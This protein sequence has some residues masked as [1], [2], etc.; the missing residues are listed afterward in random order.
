MKIF[1]I[2]TLVLTGTCVVL[3]IAAQQVD[4]NQIVRT[5]SLSDLQGVLPTLN[6]QP[7]ATNGWTWLMEAAEYNPNADVITALIQAGSPVNAATSQN[8]TSALALAAYSNPSA[9]VVSALLRAGADVNARNRYGATP[10][11]LAAWKNPNPQVVSVLLQGG[12]DADLRGYN[13][14]TALNAA[15]QNPA[16]Q[17]TAAYQQLTEA[18]S[19]FCFWTT[20][21]YNIDIYL[22]GS[23]VGKLTS[24]FTSGQPSWGQSGTLLVN[25][26]PGSYTVVGKLENGTEVGGPATSS[27]MHH[28]LFLFPDDLVAQAVSQ[29]QASNASAALGSLS[30][31]AHST[32]SLTGN[33]AFNQLGNI[34]SSAQKLTN[35]LSGNQ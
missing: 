27:L 17:N 22:N 32:A 25:V 34:F 14:G 33:N 9:D 21:N 4:A 3:P 2:V 7:N 31:I 35:A 1:R 23:Y 6:L 20:G 16:M 12:A 26:D 13:G 15:N 11:I 24:H 10:L 19:G 30:S 5:G 18:M 8:N 28:M 29:S